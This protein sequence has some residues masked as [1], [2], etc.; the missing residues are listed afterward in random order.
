MNTKSD[1]LH[2]H[3][4]LATAAAANLIS[5]TECNKPLESPADSISS[6]PRLPVAIPCT[7]SFVGHQVPPS[8]AANDVNINDQ[9]RV[10]FP[11]ATAAA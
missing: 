8:H 7:D 1:N 10:F 11:P 5:F 2:Q 6:C 3:T 4:S 9:N